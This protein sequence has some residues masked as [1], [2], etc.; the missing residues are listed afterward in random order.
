MGRRRGGADGDGRRRPATGRRDEVAVSGRRFPRS[1]S[2]VSEGD[3]RGWDEWGSGGA[4][5][6]G[7]GRPG[8]LREWGGP[9]RLVGW[10]AGP[11]GPVGQGGLSPI[12]LFC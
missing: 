7:F 9:A 12:L 6:F 8:E 1:R 4:L 10:P 3:A 5:G 2:G 11:F